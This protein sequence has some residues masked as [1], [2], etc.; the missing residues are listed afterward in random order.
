MKKI[1]VF[2]LLYLFQS[3]SS[4]CTIPVWESL[5]AKPYQSMEKADIVFFGKLIE[6]NDLTY[7]EQTVSFEVIEIYKGPKIENVI[8]RNILG[9]SCSKIFIKKDSL[10]YVYATLDT[11]GN[12]Y[13]INDRATFISQKTAAKNNFKLEKT[14]N[15]RLWLNV[16]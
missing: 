5:V 13:I 12:N 14:H 4:A 9:S 16:R 11:N 2:F 10:Y 8:I 15:K 6:F 1:V 3:T 7:S